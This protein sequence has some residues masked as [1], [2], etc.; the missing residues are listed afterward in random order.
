[1]SI[2]LTDLQSIF[3]TETPPNLSLSLSL[4]LGHS[5]DEKKIRI[6][7]LRSHPYPYI[8][9]SHLPITFPS[10]RDSTSLRHAHTTSFGVRSR[11]ENQKPPPPAESTMMQ[12]MANHSEKGISRSNPT[13]PVPSPH[14]C[15]PSA[16]LYCSLLH[17]ARISPLQ[18][19]S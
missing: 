18:K 16:A 8:L 19:T 2:Q 7:C 13:E 1:M 6:R 3:F 9:I 10:L 14:R 17:H 5:P 4:S 11:V 15:C 12:G